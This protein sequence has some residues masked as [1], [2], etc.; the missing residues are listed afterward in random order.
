M[1][2]AYM[3]QFLSL[4]LEDAKTTK[5]S[6]ATLIK[7]LNNG[8]DY[9][10]QQIRK[11]YLSA[12]QVIDAQK[13]A[14][15]GEY[16]LSSLT[17]DVLHG[18]QGIRKVK[19]YGGQYCTR[20]DITERKKE[21]NSYLSGSSNNP[22]YY[23]KDNKIYVSNGTTSPVIDIYYYKNPNP[24]MYYFT[25]TATSPAAKD[26]FIGDDNQGLSAI[27][28]KYNGIPVYSVTQGS[29]H[30]VTDYVGTSRTFTVSPDAT[31]NFGTEI[32][33]FIRR[34]E[35]DGYSVKPAATDADLYLETSELNFALQEVIMSLAEAQL[36]SMDS[37]ID[38]RTN[39]KAMAELVIETLNQS[40]IPPA[41]IGTRLPA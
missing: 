34:P 18:S 26:T 31:A 36:W 10:C 28:D 4:R 33:Y 5:F 41:G 8:Q 37:K 7:A 3:T 35:L 27:D 13:T 1:N 17:Y 14:T 9:L 22:L 38:R 40:Y 24:L 20:I 19:I 25:T 12:L 6:P 23:V 32:M 11:E 39:A 15:N 2:T 30:I 21:E 29:H 16:A